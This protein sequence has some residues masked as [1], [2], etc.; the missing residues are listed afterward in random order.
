MSHDNLKDHWSAICSEKE[1]SC[2]AT[3]TY[4]VPP[5]FCVWGHSVGKIHRC[6]M[7]MSPSRWTMGL[8]FLACVGLLAL[9]GM[10]DI[11]YLLVCLCALVWDIWWLLYSYVVTGIAFLL[12]HASVRDSGSELQSLFTVLPVVLFFFEFTL[13]HHCHSFL[14]RVIKLRSGGSLASKHFVSVKYVP[15]SFNKPNSKYMSNGVACY[16]LCIF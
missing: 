13:K 15:E 6:I 7:F 14:G 9:P 10:Y 11:M 2:W 12:L 1:T 5:F 4:L 16:F 3:L 8:R